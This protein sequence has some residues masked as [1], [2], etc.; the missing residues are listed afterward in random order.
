MSARVLAALLAFM[1]VSPAWADGSAELRSAFAQTLKLT[2]L[3]A[4]MLELPSGKPV[5]SVD[6]QAPYRYRVTPAAGA[7]GAASVIIGD[8]MYLQADGRPMNIPTPR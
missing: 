6:Y 5:S 1:F 3:R 7:A 8:T 2:A 4:T